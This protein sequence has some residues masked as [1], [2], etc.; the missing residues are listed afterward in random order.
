MLILT[1][2]RLPDEQ[3]RD[4]IA[5][6]DSCCIAGL[7]DYSPAGRALARTTFLNRLEMVLRQITVHPH[8]LRAVMRDTGTII[9]GSTPLSFF[10]DSDNH[11]MPHD[12]DF[13]SP[14][15]TFPQMRHFILHNLGGLETYHRT[16]DSADTS[17]HY[18]ENPAVCERSVFAVGGTI[19]D[20]LRSRT[21]TALSPIASF[22]LTLVMNYI[23]ADE[24]CIAYPWLLDSEATIIAPRRHSASRVE[25]YRGRGYVVGS[26]L[27]WAE[28]HDANVSMGHCPRQLRYFGDEQCFYFAFDKPRESQFS[29]AFW[30]FG[31][32]GCG[33]EVCPMIF[34]EPKLYWGTIVD[35]EIVHKEP[36]EL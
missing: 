36:P 19:V 5:S 20:L 9:T 7:H 32:V 28:E 14:Y 34:V 33:T 31:G 2:I 18:K 6:W 15:D 26:N 27:Q 4:V 12:I 24:F 25:K 1:D 8:A 10:H 35:N 30:R 23:S 29:T 13:I 11:W 21:P 22:D 16:L 17:A 3:C